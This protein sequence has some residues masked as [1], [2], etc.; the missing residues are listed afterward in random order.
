MARYGYERVGTESAALLESESSRTFGHAGCTLIFEAGPLAR[1][2]G[3]VD[4]DAIRGAIESA[5][6]RVP[7]FRRKLR[8][9]PIE[10]HPIW[11][12]DHEFNLDYH[13]RHT[14][15]PRPGSLEQLRRVAARLQAQRLDRSRPLWGVWVVEGLAEGR[16]ALLAKLHNALYE[17]ADPD[18]LEVLLDPDPAARSEPAPPHRPRPI[19]SALELVRDELVRQLRLPRRLV[20]RWSARLDDDPVEELRSAARR[21][22]KL[23]G[24]SVRSTPD[25][26]F[27]GPIGPHRRFDHLSLRLADAR[28]IRDVF[29]GTIHDVI[30]ATLTSAVSRYLRAHFVN[31]ATLDFRVAVPVSLRDGAEQERVGEWV[32]E[33][34]IWESDPVRCFES[35]CERTAARQRETPGLD[36]RSLSVPRWT[37]TRRLAQGVRAMSARAPVSLRLVNVPGP[38]IPLYLEGAKLLASYGKVPLGAHGGL[39]IAVMSYDGT[40]CWGLNADFDLVPDLPEFSD[41]IRD[42]FDALVRAAAH[43]TTP[44]SVVRGG[45]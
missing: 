1:P 38:Q 10:N 14:S 42:A 18:L 35:V 31:P 36:A 8:R 22:L 27:N 23:L 13:V 21:T 12:D 6:Y 43:R 45:A 20:E 7:R 34:P 16:F 5:L 30:L 19:P 40:L 3:G 15:L 41:A 25:T 2:D 24:Y 37:G 26:P 4:F 9:V 28:R 11:V 32:L 29:G 17:D 33:L 39:G 44:L